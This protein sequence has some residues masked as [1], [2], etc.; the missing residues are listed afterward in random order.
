MKNPAL[1]ALFEHELISSRRAFGDGFMKVLLLLVV[2]MVLSGP[3]A[4]AE[5]T[6]LPLGIWQPVEVWVDGKKQ[7]PERSH[8]K[9][10][11]NERKQWAFGDWPDYPDLSDAKLA[12]GR[13]GPKWLPQGTPVLPRHFDIWTTIDEELGIMILSLLRSNGASEQRTIKKYDLRDDR[14]Y[15]LQVSSTWQTA[16]K[17]WGYAERHGD[18]GGGFFVGEFPSAGPKEF[19]ETDRV[20]LAALKVPAKPKDT[21]TKFLA[22]SIP[23]LESGGRPIIPRPQTEVVVYERVIAT[24]PKAKNAQ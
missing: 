21:A 19:P 5:E 4:R 24:E 14:L 9:L 16:K 17:W 15:V 18:L 3:S 7:K 1:L 13:Y 12:D 6:D 8:F 20:S 22:K 10:F 2:L 11:V 23:K